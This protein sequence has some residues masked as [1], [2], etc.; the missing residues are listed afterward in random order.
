MP[1]PPPLP[2]HQPKTELSLVTEQPSGSTRRLWTAVGEASTVL[3]CSYDRTP[4]FKKT[5]FNYFLIIHMESWF[6][7]QFW[8]V[9]VVGIFL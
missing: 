8:G 2:P 7:V 5:L 9:G 6:S 3:K 4:R 1:S